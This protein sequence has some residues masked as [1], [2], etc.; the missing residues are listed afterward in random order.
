MVNMFYKFSVYLPSIGY[1]TYKKSS[2]AQNPFT[3]EVPMA[4]IQE[5][6]AQVIQKV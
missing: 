2:C 4:K 3:Q 5:K 6:A 1:Y